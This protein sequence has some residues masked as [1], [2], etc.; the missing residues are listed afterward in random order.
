M[1]H[2]YLRKVW[3]QNSFSHITFGGDY[4]NSYAYERYMEL[5]DLV[6]K[7]IARGE[8]ELAECYRLELDELQT[9]YRL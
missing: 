5:Q 3:G 2:F 6:V 1:L 8:E 4:M 7:A 9:K